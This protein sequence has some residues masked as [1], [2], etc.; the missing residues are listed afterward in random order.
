MWSGVVYAC[1]KQTYAI[2]PVRVVLSVGLSSVAD[3]VDDALD[4]DGAAVGHF[5]GKGLA[6]HEV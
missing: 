1:N 5:R 6:F 4:G 3:L 2:W